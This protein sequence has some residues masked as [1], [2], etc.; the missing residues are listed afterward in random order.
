MPSFRR[1]LVLSLALVS[2]GCANETKTPASPSSP[3]AK[4]Y[5]PVI[6]PGR[7]VCERR[8]DGCEEC[9]CN[10]EHRELVHPAGPPGP[11]R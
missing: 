9:T 2:L 5:K 6:C 1:A 7:T 8:P 4:A 11:Q 3:C 10:H